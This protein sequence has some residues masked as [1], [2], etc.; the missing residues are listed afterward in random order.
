MAEITYKIWSGDLEAKKEAILKPFGYIKFNEFVI[1]R[2]L[3]AVYFTIHAILHVVLVPTRFWEYLTVWQLFVCAVYFD[4]LLIAH[5]IN[6]DFDKE[7]YIP[8]PKVSPE[9]I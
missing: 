4:L 2:T 5:I 1:F 7:R 9:E 6:G 3:Y 8:P